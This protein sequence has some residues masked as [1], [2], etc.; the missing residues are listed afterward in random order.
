M[1]LSVFCLLDFGSRWFELRRC[2]A[3]WCPPLHGKSLTI[4]CLHYSCWQFTLVQTPKG[5]SVDF[6]LKA[7][8][9]NHFWI[10]LK[11]GVLLTPVCSPLP[12][13]WFINHMFCTQVSFLL[14]L[15][16]FFQTP[17]LTLDM[18]VFVRTDFVWM[19]L[20]GIGHYFSLKV[21]KIFSLCLHC[22]VMP[23]H[24]HTPGLLPDTRKV[25]G[26]VREGRNIL[27]LVQIP[28]NKDTATQK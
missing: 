22:V 2:W 18:C 1:Q 20:H 26:C 14:P 5:M 12:A 24:S 13:L 21:T 17:I 15:P 25:L 27:S 28:W 23:I 11:D 3:Q 6:F 16:P 4:L 8:L 19:S 10:T 9:F 7:I